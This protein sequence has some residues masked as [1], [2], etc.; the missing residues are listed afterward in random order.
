M[1]EAGVVFEEKNINSEE[2]TS[3]LLEVGGRSQ[4]PFLIDDEKNVKLYESSEIIEYIQK[5]YMQ[6]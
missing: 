4:V 6:T 1:N 5:N 2:N 3:E